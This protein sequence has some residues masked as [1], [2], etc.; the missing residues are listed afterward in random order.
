LQ[1]LSGKEVCRILEV[2]G[3]RMVRQQGSHCIM[4]QRTEQGTVTVP[5]PLHNPLRRGTLLSIIR[6]C[7]LSKSLFETDR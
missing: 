6:Q 1:V 5:V 3:F 7:G 4:Q 2:S